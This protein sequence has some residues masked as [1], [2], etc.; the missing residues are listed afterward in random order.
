MELVER[1]RLMEALE[2][3]LRSRR[4]VFLE[5]HELRER[6]A[7]L[8]QCL[9]SAELVP[10][11]AKAELSSAISEGGGLESEDGWWNGFK[12]GGHPAPTFD[13]LTSLR[14][15]HTE[16]WATEFH[17][18]GHLIA[19][20]WSFPECRVFNAS[21][22]ERQKACVADFYGK[23]FK[24]FAYMANKVYAAIHYEAEVYVTA[25]I[26]RANDLPLVDGRG[27]IVD[28]RTKRSTARWP[29]RSSN[30]SELSEIGSAMASQFLRLFGRSVQKSS[31]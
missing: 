20:I 18:D 10:D 29:N 8:F 25:T 9:P 19:G 17:A 5:D 15:N 21:R 30:V 12:I 11:L 16:G 4:E 13:G 27:H 28:S 1:L 24:D 7:L 23:A 2:H 26:H 22:E 3:H 14:R 6:P 31:S